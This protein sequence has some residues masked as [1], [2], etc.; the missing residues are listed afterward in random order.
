MNNE[1]NTQMAE[2]KRQKFEY[3]K[4]PLLEKQRLRCNQHNWD[5]RLQKRAAE[6]I[7]SL[8]GKTFDIEALQEEHKIYSGYFHAP[9]LRSG[10]K[11]QE[12]VG[13]MTG[14]YILKSRDSQPLTAKLKNV[15]YDNSVLR[16]M[17]G[18]WH[19]NFERLNSEVEALEKQLAKEKKKSNPGRK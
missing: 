17:D 14:E 18:V 7:A 5:P 2:A 12:V 16:K 11:A 1:P 4:L 9:A 6:I 19:T 3:E 8:G 15:E 10:Y 13:K